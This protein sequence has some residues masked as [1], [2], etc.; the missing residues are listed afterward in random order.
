MK[1]FIQVVV[2]LLFISCTSKPKLIKNQNIGEALGTTFSIIYISEYELD[3]QKEIDS[4][5]QAFNKSMSTY[6]PDSDISKINSGDSTLIID[7]MFRDVFMQSKLV[8]Y[9]TNGYFDPT[10]GVLVD[11]WGF[12]PGKQIELDSTKVDSLM[13]YVG[14]QKIGLTQDYRIV[15]IKKEISFDFNAIAKGYAIDRLGQMLNEKGIKHYLVEVGGEVLTKGTNIIN[16]KP[17]K[18]A[19][20]DPNDLSARGRAAIVELQDM[21]LASSGNYRKFRIDDETGQKYVH[22]INPKTGYTKNSNILSATVVTASCIKAD[23]YAT[24]FMAMDLNKTKDLLSKRDDLEAF[25]IYLDEQGNSQNF[26]TKGFE[27]IVVK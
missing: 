11:A 2:L 20:D 5:F 26:M 27:K 22:T 16:E 23:A 6:L 12:G 13:Q 17:W 10:V 18:V 4:I 14:F 24:A 21:A 9:E 25:V 19:I 1:G 7:Q 8:H 3:Y 15:K